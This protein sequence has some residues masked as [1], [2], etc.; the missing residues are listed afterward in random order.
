[1]YMNAKVST[2]L[3]N[4]R[5]WIIQNVFH[6]TGLEGVFGGKTREEDGKPNFAQRCYVCCF[7]IT[8][9]MYSFPNIFYF[10]FNL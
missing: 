10:I 1:M 9:F 6:C 2:T 7:R 8:F 5:Q 4:S 3:A